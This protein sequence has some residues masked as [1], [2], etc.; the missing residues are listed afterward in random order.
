MCEPTTIML[1]MAAASAAL[2][3]H[4]KNEQADAMNQQA[5]NQHEMAVDT[6]EAQYEQQNRK[7]V[8]DQQ[9]ATTESVNIQQDVNSRMAT[10]RTQAG[11]AGV[12]G[13]S[14]NNMLLNLAGKGLS[15]QTTAETNYARTVAGNRD[16]ANEIARGAK[17]TV[18][19]IQTAAG[20]GWA[21]Y[22]G[23]AL[24]VGSAYYGNKAADKRAGIK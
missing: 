17:G 14:V 19:G 12:M 11:A 10:A 21:D 22:A 18:A 9:N 6:A 7:A 15:A 13:T 16:Q 3:V 23:A 5:E 1:A 8:E 2:T 24:Q 4:S 20:A